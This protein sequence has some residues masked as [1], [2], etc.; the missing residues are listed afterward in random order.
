MWQE[1][2]RHR[3]ADKRFEDFSNHRRHSK[4]IARALRRKADRIDRHNLFATEST[5]TSAG[6]KSSDQFMK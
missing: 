5:Q 1:I 4:L 2:G 3:E 6:A